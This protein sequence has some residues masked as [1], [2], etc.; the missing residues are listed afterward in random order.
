MQHMPLCVHC[1]NA[2]QLWLVQLTPN[3]TVFVV[4]SL[5]CLLFSTCLDNVATATCDLGCLLLHMHFDVC[6]YACNAQMFDFDV[7]FYVC[8]LQSQA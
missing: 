3:S 8:R 4:L 2:P 1:S 5:P 7:C 6:C